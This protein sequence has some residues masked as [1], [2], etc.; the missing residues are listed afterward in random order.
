MVQSNAPKRWRSLG[1]GS[2]LGVAIGVFLNRTQPFAVSRADF[3]IQIV[4]ACFISIALHEAGHA[5]AAVMA[6]FRLVIVA[7]WPLQFRRHGTGWSLGRMEKLRVGGFVLPVP[8]GSHDLRRRWFEIIAAGPAVSLIA[9][10][11]AATLYWRFGASWPG[12]AS[13]QL[14]CLAF[15]NLL[16]GLVG[17][18]PI[19]SP[20]AVTDGARIRMLCQNGAEAERFL[21]LTSLLGASTSGV[22]PKEWPREL[23]EMLDIPQ[24]RSRDALASQMM[25]Y[26]WLIDSG[27]A[28][29]ASEVLNWLFSSDL[30]EDLKPIWQLERAWFEARFV[31]NLSAAK[32]WL[33]AGVRRDKRPAYLCGLYKAQAAIALLEHRWADLE[34]AAHE[35]LK[36]CDKLTDPGLAIAIRDKIEALLADRQALRT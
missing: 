27:R 28:E 4:A 6:G 32:E 10:G 2:A 19:R 31:R 30:P 17:L 26:N 7:V 18:L 21:N 13:A 3:P 14:E 8:R 25:R 35:T 34:S 22:R 20:Y 29:E 33:E 9:G 11:L 36:Q 15:W 16:F 23:V 12:A 24:D 1:I 5:T